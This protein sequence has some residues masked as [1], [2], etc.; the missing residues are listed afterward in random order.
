M[1]LM[2]KG[3][4]LG[5][6]FKQVLKDM[7]LAGVGT[8]LAGMFTTIGPALIVLSAAKAGGFS[9]ELAVSWLWA[10]YSFA[11][12]S[13]IFLALRYRVPVA[14]AYSIPGAVL[15]GKVL[16]TIPV[17]EAVGAYLIVGAVALALTLM[18]FIKK[19]VNH[20]P[21]PIMLGMVGGV[22]FSFELGLFKAAIQ[23]PGIYGIMLI[24]FFVS[25][26]FKSFARKVPPIVVAMAVGIILLILN[27]KVQSVNFNFEIAK[28]VFVMPAFSLRAL[29]NIS[30]PLFFLVIG[31]QNIQAVGVL[32]AEGYK[33]PIN[34]I[35]A[36][37]SIGAF[38]NAIFGA[39]PAVTA[40]PS[41]AVL[42]SRV[43]NE[44]PE[45]RY[46][47]AFCTGVLKLILTIFLKVAVDSVNMVP[48]EF[49]AALAGIAI[50][51]VIL[52]AFRGAFTTY[53]RY[54]AMV[55]FWVAVTN[56]SIL[57]IGA[58]FWSIVFGVLASVVLELEDF[59]RIFRKDT[60]SATPTQAT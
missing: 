56:L 29:I 11:G 51:D 3:Y 17:Q 45:L 46:V 6:S 39:H 9:D 53:F 7:N 31:V 48:R 49:T 20:I 4:P 54:G 42:C 12:I 1:E 43:A 2:E 8:G 27:G 41:T 28:P 44:K 18:G 22:L 36:V 30:F 37:P 5:Q 23:Q 13:S 19:M 50:F 59:K 34:A 21:V 14:I 57:D 32:M 47:A 40:G 24:S 52:N 25:M 26:A 10:L 58:P 33:P 35:Y 38:Y 60:A 15:L 55:A 16:P